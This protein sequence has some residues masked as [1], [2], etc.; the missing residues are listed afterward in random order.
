MSK[1]TTTTEASPPQAGYRSRVDWDG[2]YWVA[3]PN[4]VGA[5]C[6]PTPEAPRSAGQE[7]RVTGQLLA[8][9]ARAAHQFVTA[10][11]GLARQ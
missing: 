7:G 6:A 11:V 9:P 4:A 8:F 1:K 10:A 2:Q 5:H 3:V